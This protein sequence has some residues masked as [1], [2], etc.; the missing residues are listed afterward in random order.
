MAEEEPRPDEAGGPEAAAPA[1]SLEE[2]LH[3]AQAQAAQLKDQFLRALADAEN[4]RR[5]AQREREDANKYA[6]AGFAKEMVAVADNL[7]RALEAI[8]A[9]V[10]QTDDN[11]RNLATGVELT[12]RQLAAVFERFA[13]RRV[14]PWG[15]KFDSNLHQAMLEVPGTG[16]PAGTVVQVLQAGYVLNDR[17]LRP[18]L[19]GIAKAEPVSPA[20]DDAA[21]EGPGE[22]GHRVDTVA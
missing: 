3:A 13:I 19:V 4:A 15:E 1:P 16:Q 5:R 7:H 14:E 20:P 2:Q 8:P 9:E 17:L 10:L 11:L 21:P 12:E 18:A 6:I 22:P